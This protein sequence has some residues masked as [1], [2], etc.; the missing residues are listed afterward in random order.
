MKKRSE[1]VLGRLGE[2]IQSLRTVKGRAR[3]QALKELRQV[4]EKNMTASK[5]VISE[6]GIAL[7]LTLLG[8]FTSHMVG[9]EVVAIL[10]NVT[11]DTQSRSNLLQPARISLLVDMLNEGSILTKSNCTRLMETLVEEKNYRSE[12]IASHSLLVGLM[13]LVKDKRSP[14]GVLHGLRPPQNSMLAQPSPKSGHCRGSC[15]S[16]G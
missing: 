10:V 7:L 14:S 13:R 15:S 5:T 3:V 6:G 9:S 1:D 8:P 11:L 16:V 4:V 2:R 12:V